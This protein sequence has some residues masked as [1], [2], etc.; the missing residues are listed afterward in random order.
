MPRARAAK[1][2][3]R[4]VPG[5]RRADLRR[6][7]LLDAL[8]QLLEHKPLD[9]IGIAEITRKAD[10]TRSAFYFYFPTKAAAVAALLSDLYEQLETVAAS[11][12]AGG[13]GTPRERVQTGFEESI[14]VWRTHAGLLVAMFDAT[15]Q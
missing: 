1:A 3:P 9:Q 12:Y 15:G 5:P 8:E 7:A 4:Y 14:K 6:Q 2:Q 11:W 10:V 13:P